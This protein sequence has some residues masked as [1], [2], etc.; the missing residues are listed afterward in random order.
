MRTPRG[1]G[2]AEE[3]TVELWRRISRALDELLELD[4]ERQRL[5][6]PRICA[7]DPLVLRWTRSFLEA[8]ARA[9]DFLERPA[10][11]GTAGA[12]RRFLVA[13]GPWPRG[14]ACW[15]VKG[16]VGSGTGDGKRAAVGKGPEGDER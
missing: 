12:L 3:L 6:L 11:S 2:M 14:P 7:G 16:R 13:P 15:K 4:P 9:G 5:L 10:A 8:S 1:D